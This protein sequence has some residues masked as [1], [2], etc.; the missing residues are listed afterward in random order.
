MGPAVE[1][2]EQHQSLTVTYDE[3]G[4]DE[5]NEDAQNESNHELLPRCNDS[6][7]DGLSRCIFGDEICR[8][9]KRDEHGVH[10]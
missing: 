9:E 6:C 5:D 8:R 1:S 3:K 4:I 2:Q 10:C 7:K